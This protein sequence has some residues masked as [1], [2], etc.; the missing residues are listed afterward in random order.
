MKLLKH[1]GDV[2]SGNDACS[3]ILQFVEGFVWQTKQK[4]I[5]MIK[6]GCDKGVN[7]YGSFIG[8]G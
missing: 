7:Q 1:R 8:E 3:R 2:S 5:P 6:A 4:S